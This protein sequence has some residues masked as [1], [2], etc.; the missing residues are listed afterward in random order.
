MSIAPNAGIVALDNFK[1][2]TV[3]ADGLQGQVPK[4]L[5]GQ[6]DYVLTASG[7]VPGGSIPGLG[8]MAS[9]DADNVAIT[10]GAINGTTVGTTTPAAGSFTT[11]IGG[12]GS[13]NY[14]QITGGAT[15]KAVQFQTLGTDTNIS[16]AVQPKGTGAIDLA[17]GSSGINISN[18]G[19]VTAITRTGTGS[20][21]TSFPTPALS[22]PTTAGGIQAVVAVI[23]CRSRR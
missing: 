19:T 13:A 1:E 20:G 11:L 5:A 12:A 18:G 8:T 6:Q 4:P 14:E 17:A 21:Y 3:S 7:F 9:Q 22:A 23:S 10:G 15:T 2:P 16:V